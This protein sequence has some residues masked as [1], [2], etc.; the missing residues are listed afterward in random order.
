MKNKILIS[1]CIVMLFAGQAFSAKGDETYDKLK[2]MIDV[3]QMINE[4][5]V[6][7]K[8]TKD[9]VSGAIKGMV[10]SLDPFSQY[11]EEK[12]YNDMKSETEGAFSGVGIQIESKNNYVTVVSPIP[13]TPAYKAGILPGDRIFKIDGKSAINMT[14]SDASNLM[15]GKFGTKVTLTIL[16]DNTPEPLTFTLKRDKIKITTV[17][18]VLLDGGIVYIRLSEFSAPSAK[19]ISDALN[20]YSKDE[21]TKING[22]ILD[23]RN[24]PGGLINS[25]ID[26]ISI[27]VNSDKPVLT[28]RGRDKHI[29]EEY[30]TVGDAQYPNT[31]LVVLINRGSAS[32]SEIVSGTFQDLKRALIIGANSFGKGSVQ[33]VLPLPD[34]TALRLTIA[35]YYLP[36]GRPITRGDGPNDRNGITPDIEIALPIE[37]E[38]R[39]YSQSNIIF[40]DDKKTKVEVISKAEHE[41]LLAQKSTAAF[42]ATGEPI[43]RLEDDVLKKAIDVIK[44][45]RVSQL[46]NSSKALDKDKQLA[47]KELEEALEAQKKRREAES[48]E[49][50]LDTDKI[51]NDID[52][53][54][55]S[56][57]SLP[58]K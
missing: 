31:P 44:E 49:N 41:K 9:L 1:V 34:G 11:M 58:R 54:T 15:R 47:K 3:M 39:L 52:A 13:D 32:A 50:K 45:G 57:K 17:R 38:I 40:M 51:T 5:Y 55:S 53:S 6:D 30:K 36:S 12:A 35:K 28:T 19:D 26:T 42:T 23:L 18:S 8:D 16:R 29:L 2:I 27:F 20:N 33:T 43:T 21:K 56:V 24:N 48:K 7:D 25:A 37:D 10:G 14:T 4:R 46:I 22:V